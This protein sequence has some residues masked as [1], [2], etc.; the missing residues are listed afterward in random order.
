[1]DGLAGSGKSTLMANVVTKCIKNHKYQ[2]VVHFVGVAP[3]STSL[4]RM[5]TRIWFE[6]KNYVELD[7][8]KDTAQLRAGTKTLFDEASKRI[9]EKEPR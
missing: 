5:L 1:M 4:P 9:M 3:G 2:T 7:V 6:C 8:P